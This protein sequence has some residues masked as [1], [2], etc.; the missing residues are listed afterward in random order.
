MR[1]QVGHTSS[2]SDDVEALHAELDEFKQLV[3]GKLKT[4]KRK[5]LMMHQEIPDPQKLTECSR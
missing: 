3:V 2:V 4:L 1:P 5:Q